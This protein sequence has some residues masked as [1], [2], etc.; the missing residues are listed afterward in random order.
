MSDALSYL[1]RVRQDAMKSYFRF[2]KSAGGHL[3]PKTRAII[4]VIT[5]VDNQTETGFRQ[6]LPKALEA[7]V[8]ADEILDGLLYAFPTLGLTKI[9]WAVD[10]MLEM[11]LPEFRPEQLEQ[12]PAW[13]DII[14]LDD[15]VD[16]KPVFVT[17]GEKRYFIHKDGDDIRVFDNHCPHQATSIP[18]NALAEYELTCP[19]HG[20]KFDIRTG[21]CTDRGDKPLRRIEHRVE[22]GRLWVF[23][24]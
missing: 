9:V 15:I 2:L 21:E 1:M 13:M 17:C 10:I 22:D 6:Y 7:G 12:P 19:R 3:D 11:D 23:D 24:H 14:A 20:W 16:G 18:E 5:K 8:S 4:S